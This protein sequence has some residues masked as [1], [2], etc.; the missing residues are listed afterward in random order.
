MCTGRNAR[1]L[2]CLLVTD[3]LGGKWQREQHCFDEHVRNI[4]HPG[5]AEQICASGTSSDLPSS[6]IWRFLPPVLPVQAVPVQTVPMQDM[7]MQDVHAVLAQTVPVQAVLVQVV[8][9]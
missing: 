9:V 1:S 4:E 3:V 5:N 8:P 7:P 6:G 2:P